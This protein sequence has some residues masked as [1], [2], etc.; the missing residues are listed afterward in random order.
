[1]RWPRRSGESRKIIIEN[2]ACT[3]LTMDDQKFLYVSVGQKDEVRRYE[4]TPDGVVDTNGTVVAGGHGRGDG[5]NQLNFPNN[6]F[7]GQDHSVYISDTG[8]HRVMK[9]EKG[10]PEGTIVAGGQGKGDALTQLS[11]PQ[12]LL[13]DSFGTV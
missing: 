1:M 11:K 7:V 2:I 3:G 9:W 13:V 10:A 4:L 8:N 12:G 6:V 5:L